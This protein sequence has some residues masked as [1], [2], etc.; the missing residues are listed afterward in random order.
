MEG[1]CTDI[2]RASE[3]RLQDTMNKLGKDTS[4]SFCNKKFL[5]T[6]AEMKKQ[7]AGCLVPS[8]PLAIV[9]FACR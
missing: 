3:H 1:R 6:A 8:L 5:R 9:A 7:K 4:A 2:N